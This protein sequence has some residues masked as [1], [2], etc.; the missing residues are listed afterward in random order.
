MGEGVRQGREKGVM[1]MVVDAI[2][3]IYRLADQQE[4]GLF[5]AAHGEAS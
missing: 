2:D 1:L 4:E 3:A 5:M